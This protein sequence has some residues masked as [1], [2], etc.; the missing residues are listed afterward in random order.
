MPPF[1]IVGMEYHEGITPLF[2]EVVLGRIQVILLWFE[3]PIV[4][5]FP[6]L[7]VQISIEGFQLAYFLLILSV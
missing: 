6:L 4:F 5:E 7:G 1:S 3:K 2:I